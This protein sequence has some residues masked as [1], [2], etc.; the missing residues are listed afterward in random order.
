MLEKERTETI[1]TSINKQMAKQI[2]VSQCNE[3]LL[4]KKIITNTGNK[5]ES[6]KHYTE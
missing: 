4:G 5:D 1:Q 6:Q 2:V 3:I